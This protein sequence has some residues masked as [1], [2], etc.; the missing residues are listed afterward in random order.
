[1][2]GKGLNPGRDVDCH[3]PYM[4][5]FTKSVLLL[6][7]MLN[8]F[9]MSI[10]LLSLVRALE[11]TVFFRKLLRS[12]II[13]LGVFVVFAWAGNAIFT[14]VLQVRFLSFLIFGGITFLIIGMRMIFMKGNPIESLEPDSEHVSGS[15]AIP[16]LVGPGT[17]SA[18]VLAG[19]RLHLVLAVVAIV[20]ALGL[21]IGGILAFKRIH[22]FVLKRNERLLRR[23]TEV[24]A[25]ITALFTGTFAIEM[26]LTGIESWLN[27]LPARTA[28]GLDT[29]NIGFDG[30]QV[31]PF[32]SGSVG[33]PDVEMW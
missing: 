4:D 7:V 11:F 20:L 31:L 30:L 2:I 29:H 33:R 18:S 26:I 8:P 13:S 32:S 23:Y 28:G 21:A 24:A 25:R 27:Q 22:D 17:I 15:I 3:Q 19:S 12:G 16:F 14:D 5:A 10:F 9:S 6:F 1:M